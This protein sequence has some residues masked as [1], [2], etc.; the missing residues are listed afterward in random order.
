M[1]LTHRGGDRYMLTIRLN[2]KTDLDVIKILLS[3][4]G[5]AHRGYICDAIT[6][7]E[8]NGAPL[9]REI[10]NAEQVLLIKKT[11][12]DSIEK[13]LSDKEFVVGYTEGK[14]ELTDDMIGFNPY[15]GQ[16]ISP[17]ILDGL[18]L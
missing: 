13:I 6:A 9:P 16:D 17:D 10:S 3:M 7:H 5:S 8:N 1:A 12:R 15:D 2:R 18:S 4:D 14:R 11:I